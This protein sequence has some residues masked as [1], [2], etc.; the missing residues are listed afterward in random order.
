MTFKGHFLLCVQLATCHHCPIVTSRRGLVYRESLSVL[1]RNLRAPG[2]PYRVPAPRLLHNKHPCRLTRPD[3]PESFA[4]TGSKAQCSMK[5]LLLDHLRKLL[6]LSP[7][8]RTGGAG[9]GR[10]LPV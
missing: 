8:H 2:G 10:H 1:S 7:A 4:L 9:G 6:T 5:H 3:L